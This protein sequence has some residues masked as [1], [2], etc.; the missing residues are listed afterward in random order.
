MEANLHFQILQLKFFKNNLKRNVFR[1]RQNISPRRIETLL[2]YV[3]SQMTALDKLPSDDIF[4]GFL[5]LKTISS[6]QKEEKK[7]KETRKIVF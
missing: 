1:S 7:K 6:L 3:R 4:H 5:V 2:H